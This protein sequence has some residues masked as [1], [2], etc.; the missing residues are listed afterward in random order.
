[1]PAKLFKIDVL[2]RN[3]NLGC[4]KFVQAL[5]DFK[6]VVDSCFENDL[7]KDYKEKIAAFRQSYSDLDVSITPKVYTVPYKH[8][9]L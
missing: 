4:L 3:C 7:G 5:Q 6:A 9:T 2:M 1:M 8:S